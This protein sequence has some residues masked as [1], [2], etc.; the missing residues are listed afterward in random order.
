MNVTTVVI[1]GTL[2][3][4]VL[5]V[6]IVAFVFVYQ[7]KLIQ[8]DLKI[9]K[10]KAEYQKELLKA[11]IQAQEKERKRISQDLHDDIGAMLSTIRLSINGM[12]K[13]LSLSEQQVGKVQNTKSL[14]DE[15]VRNVRRISHDLLPATL[16][17]FGLSHALE[18]LFKKIETNTNLEVEY[19]LDHDLPKLDK[20]KELALYRITQELCNNIIK[21]ANASSIEA[22]LTRNNDNLEITLMDDGNGFYEKRNDSKSSLGLGLKNIESR[23]SMIDAE[24][25]YEPAPLKGTKVQIKAGYQNAIF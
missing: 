16:E 19:Q 1:L 15:T 10:L 18:Q 13:G 21:H 14:I 3:M 8:R 20:A 9:Q 25:N 11:T 2:A 4:L 23:L 24:I 7:K 6:T 12:V 22:W 17:E 5:A